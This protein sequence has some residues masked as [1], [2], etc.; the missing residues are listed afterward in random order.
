MLYYFISHE[1]EVLLFCKSDHIFNALLA[2]DL[3]YHIGRSKFE[4]AVKDALKHRKY[5]QQTN[6]W[7]FRD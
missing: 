4:S 5:Y 1:E 7:G 3:T 2:L 6:R